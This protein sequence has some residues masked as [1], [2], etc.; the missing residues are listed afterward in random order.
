MSPAGAAAGDRGS[1]PAS[2]RDAWSS[3]M[4]HGSRPTWFR[5]VDGAHVALACAASRRMCI[6]AHHDVP[7]RAAL[8]DRPTAPCVFDGP[9]NG[10]CFRAHVEQ[11]LVPCSSDQATSS[12]W[13]ISEATNPRSCGRIIRPQVQG[14]GICCPYFTRPQP[15]LSRPSPRSRILDASAAQKRTVDELLMH[16][17]GLVSTIQAHECS[18]YFANAGYA[19]IK[20]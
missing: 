6:L 8:H 9:I 7:R 2:I 13:T 4:R 18:N 3:S 11:L 10:E 16:I 1:G 15:D 19:S 14:C 5:C 12:S 17:G 20:P